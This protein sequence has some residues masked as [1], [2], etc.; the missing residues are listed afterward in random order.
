[1]LFNIPD[2]CNYCLAKQNYGK[3]LKDGVSN[4]T[5]RETIGM[6]EEEFL[7]KDAIVRAHGKDMK[8]ELHR[9]QKNFVIEGSKADVRMERG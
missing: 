3:P 1:M 6:E 4:E 9:R 8:K 2:Y 5:I 7:S